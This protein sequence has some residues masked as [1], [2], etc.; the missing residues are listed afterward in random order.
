MIA[1]LVVN[2][3]LSAT[4]GRI[5]K[6]SYEC[7]IMDVDGVKMGPYLLNKWLTKSFMWLNFSLLFL[8]QLTLVWKVLKLIMRCCQ[9]CCSYR[10]RHDRGQSGTMHLGSVCCASWR[11]DCWDYFAFS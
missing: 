5:N 1:S 3:W 10:H 11:T 7:E 2:V 4:M 6:W 9:A 8:L